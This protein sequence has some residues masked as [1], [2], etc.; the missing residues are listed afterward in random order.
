MP[1]TERK[2]RLEIAG[3]RIFYPH[4]EFETSS[5]MTELESNRDE[6]V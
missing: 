3:V 4:A 6:W 1:G 2:L 5:E